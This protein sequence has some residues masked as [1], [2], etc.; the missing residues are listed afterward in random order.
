MTESATP[1]TE[2]LD[3]GRAPA[4]ELARQ[5]ALL[6][7]DHELNTVADAVP[8]P[9]A[10]LNGQRQIVHLNQGGRSLLGIGTAA[11]LQGA[12]PGE[13][14]GC[15][16]A[17]HA[18][19]G[20]GTDRQCRECGAV[21]SVLAARRDGHGQRT[22][23]I[24]RGPAQLPLDLEVTAH[25]LEIGGE[26]FVLASLTD[27][28]HE[29]RRRVL[30]RLFF[31]DVLNTAGGL[32]GLSEANLASLQ[33]TPG[34]DPELARLLVTGAQ[35]LV[36]EI[37]GQRDLAAA[38]R[39]DLA[40]HPGPVDATQAVARTARTYRHH[41]AAADRTVAVVPGPEVEVHTDATLLGRVLGNLVK[42][43]LE[44]IRPGQT[45]TLGH[46]RDADRVVFRVANPGEV[47]P[48]V[49]PHLF[50]R[51]VSTK[52]AGRGLGTYSARLLVEGHLGGRVRWHSDA[53]SGTVVE[54]DLPR[55]GS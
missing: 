31:H 19:G 38:E 23:V 13:A 24:S 8:Q 22:C 26:A 30:E 49:R 42:N 17:A 6:Q 29:R 10:V 55:R 37:A 51:S 9:M 20:C 1:V 28:H 33:D 12:R 43:A 40:V 2:F 18:P 16:V 36:E 15:T 44:A 27:I 35:Q 46:R 5:H 48:A 41:P 14:L 53:A 11:E 47:D 25:L 52:G 39:G 34:G 21:L 45:V 3:A 50:S 7:A 4:A 54:V 32:L